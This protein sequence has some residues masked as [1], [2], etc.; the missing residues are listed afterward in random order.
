M[1]KVQLILQL[2]HPY[3]FIP[4]STV[5]REMSVMA[6]EAEHCTT[7]SFLMQ[8]WVFRLGYRSSQ[9]NGGGSLICNR[10]WVF[11]LLFVL[12]KSGSQTATW[13]VWPRPARLPVSQSVRQSGQSS[14]LACCPPVCSL[15]QLCI[16][17]ICFLRCLEFSQLELSWPLPI[18]EFTIYTLE[19]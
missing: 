1:E 14:Q 9:W 5:I 11:S 2:L 16:E 13:P 8:D 7:K 12:A 3:T 17:L 6:K 10:K 18:V 15:H 4:T 19:Q